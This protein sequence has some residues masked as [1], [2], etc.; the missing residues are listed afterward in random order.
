MLPQRSVLRQHSFPGTSSN[1]VI[2]LKGILNIKLNSSSNSSENAPNTGLPQHQ[3]GPNEDNLFYLCN[4][5]MTC[6]KRR[7]IPHLRLGLPPCLIDVRTIRSLDICT[8]TGRA[9]H[10]RCAQ[11]GSG[12]HTD[13]ILWHRLVMGLWHS[14]LH[15]VRFVSGAE[16]TA[17]GGAA[18]PRF[19]RQAGGPARHQRRSPASRAVPI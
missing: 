13:P 12:K 3:S 15:C 8:T 7:P 17:G 18:P 14:V 6:P 1:P 2:L 11:G 10:A 16:S 4:L 9:Y 5:E 19:L